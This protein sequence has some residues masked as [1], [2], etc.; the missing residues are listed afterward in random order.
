MNPRPDERSVAGAARCVAIPG[1]EL[2]RSIDSVIDLGETSY[3]DGPL[4][5]ASGRQHTLCVRNGGRAYAWGSSSLEDEGTGFVAGAE[6]TSCIL[7]K[8]ENAFEE[9]REKSK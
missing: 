9:L 4:V 3:S 8:V 7:A 2:A 1:E 5:Q 6:V